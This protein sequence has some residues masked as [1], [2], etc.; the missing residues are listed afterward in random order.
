MQPPAPAEVHVWRF[1]L[2]GDAAR[3]GR[4]ERILSVEERARSARFHFD[5][6]RHRFIIARAV[7]RDVLARYAGVSPAALPLTAVHGEKPHSPVVPCAHNLSHAHELGLIAVAAAGD[8]G[9]D[10]DYVDRAVDLAAVAR[11]A[12]TPREHND[13]SALPA[14]ERQAAFFSVWTRKEA[15]LKAIGDRTAFEFRDFDAA[16]AE[17]TWS[18]A[19]FAPAPGYCAAIALRSFEHR[20]AELLRLRLLD[21]HDDDGLRAGGHASGALEFADGAADLVE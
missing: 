2:T 14:G 4:L 11:I 1:P 15:V 5:T 20:D 18:I 17:Q 9:V 13:W 21:H 10:V 3:V 12:L 19:T 7:Y 8:I 6:D 16:L